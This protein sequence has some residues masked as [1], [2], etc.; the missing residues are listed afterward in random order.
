MDKKWD[1]VY[2]RAIII[3]PLYLSSFELEK[4]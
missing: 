1:R 3:A 2:R 4:G